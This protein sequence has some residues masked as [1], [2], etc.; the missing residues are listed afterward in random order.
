LAFL[1]S[2]QVTSND[3]LLNGGWPVN[4]SNGRPVLEATSLVVRLL[5][6][7]CLSTADNRLNPLAAHEWIV[8]NQNPDGG[9]GSFFGQ[10]S[11]VWLTAMAIRA[12]VQCDL[13]NPN[14]AAGIEW[15]IRGRDPLTSGWGEQPGS[16]ATVTHTA[17]VLTCLTESRLASRRPDV[18]EAI[19]RGFEWLPAH[20]DTSAIFDDAARVESYNVN[21]TEDGRQIIWQNSVWHPG[22]PFA[23]QALLRDPAGASLDIIGT[24]VRHIV[25]TQSDDGRWPN[26]DSAEGISVWSV[27][28]FVDSLCDFKRIASIPGGS[29]LTWLTDDTML[30]RRQAEKRRGVLYLYLQ[31]NLSAVRSLLKRWWSALLL[32]N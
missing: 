11:R 17:F 29:R 16:P 14:V 31:F 21:F 32:A 12:L 7:H 24:A 22:L 19:K 30:I 1:G 20:V 13:S 8:K 3:N 25:R 26:P 28:P 27:W 2:R 23:L 9:W 6:S 18:D 4:T 10:K 5:G 15:L